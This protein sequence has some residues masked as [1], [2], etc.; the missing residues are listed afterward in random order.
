MISQ[1]IE[2]LLALALNATPQELKKTPALSAGI[3]SFQNS[4]SDAPVTP[5]S[6]ETLWTLI[7]RYI[8]NPD[9]L[10]NYSVKTT[11]LLGNYAILD[12]AIVTDMYII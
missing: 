4:S 9:F 1:K 8:G 11:L 6:A 5:D 3:E 7:I 10:Q 12:V 2:T